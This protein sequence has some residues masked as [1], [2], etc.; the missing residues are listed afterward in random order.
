[1]EALDPTVSF[2]AKQQRLVTLVIEEGSE[3]VKERCKITRSG[4]GY[5]PYAEN[6][7]TATNLDKLKIEVV[8]LYTVLFTLL[9]DE[10]FI[11]KDEIKAMMTLKVIKLLK[12]EP[13]LFEDL[14]D[15]L[16][17]TRQEAPNGSN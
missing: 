15:V 14:A 3:V 10:T 17:I 1:M 16:D 4:E 12:H 11:T 2:S 8:D 5:I 6:G 7:N 13:G 9:N